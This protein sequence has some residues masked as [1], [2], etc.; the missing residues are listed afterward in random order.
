MLKIVEGAESLFDQ[1]TNWRRYLHEHPELS[2]EEVETARFV[3][4]ELMKIENIQIEEKVGGNG[5]VA[6]LTTVHGTTI[7]LRADMY[8]LP[9]IEANTHDFVSKHEGTMHACGH[10]AH[11]SMLLGAVHLL[12]E[13]FRKGQLV[14]TV[15]FIFQPAEESTDE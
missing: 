7:A 9:I 2:F 3:V 14:G 5:V 15:K 1:L 8:A 4:Q 10:D 11:T 6:T 13:Q 12:A